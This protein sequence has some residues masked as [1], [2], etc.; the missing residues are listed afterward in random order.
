MKRPIKKGFPIDTGIL[1]KLKKQLIQKVEA[2]KTEDLAKEIPVRKRS[3]LT[4]RTVTIS[5]EK[6]ITLQKITLVY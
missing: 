2:K 4:R 1:S 3:R 5:R 6:V